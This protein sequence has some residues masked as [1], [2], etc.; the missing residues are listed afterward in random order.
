MQKVLVPSLVAGVLLV[1]AGSEV[2]KVEYK[3]RQESRPL[4]PVRMQSNVCVSV[5]V[6]QGIWPRP[7][8][9]GANQNFSGYLMTEL[10]RLYEERGGSRFL[11]GTHNI[12]RFQPNGN[13]TNPLCRHPATD[14]FVFVRYEPR[15]DGMPFVMQYRITAGRLV[16]SGRIDVDVA[17]E[18]R[19]GRIQGF[20]QRRTIS[21]ILSEDMRNR[22]TM[23][24]D[25]LLVLGN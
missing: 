5:H 19:A 1:A 23:I 25:R 14:V 4:I 17:A 22:A 24:V 2:G 6:D 7:L 9:D 13:E 20:N 8:D 12:E 11:P 15:P 16:R 18:I 21:I 10:R 3:S